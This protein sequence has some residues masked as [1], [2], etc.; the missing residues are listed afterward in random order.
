MLPFVHAI[1]I[2]DWKVSTSS[3]RVWMM[4]ASSACSKLA[5]ARLV[6]GLMGSLSCGAPRAYCQKA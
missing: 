6:L 1:D 5:S 3:I 4:L 2:E